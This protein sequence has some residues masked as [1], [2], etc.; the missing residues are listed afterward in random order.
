MVAERLGPAIGHTTLYTSPADKAIGFAERLFASPR[1]R[2]GKAVI[3]KL[4]TEERSVIAENKNTGNFTAINFTGKTSGYGHSY[5]RDNPVVSSD[6]VLLLRYGFQAGSPGR[7]LQHIGS[8]FWQFPADYP[9]G[10]I[11]P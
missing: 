8:I 7:P 1:G 2:L 5:F 3:S 6:L 11:I 10:A 9:K 4:S